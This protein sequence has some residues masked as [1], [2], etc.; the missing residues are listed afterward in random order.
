MIWRSIWA[1][2][3]R[4]SD[5]V[6]DQGGCGYRLF[7]GGERCAA[8]RQ[9]ITI[10]A[11]CNGE[12]GVRENRAR[13]PGAVRRNEAAAERGEDPEGSIRPRVALRRLRALVTAY[14]HHMTDEVHG[15][16]SGRIWRWLQQELSPARGLGQCSPDTPCR[17][18]E[19]AAGGTR[20]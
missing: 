19:T 3:W 2:R 4:V 6:A 13:L 8:T 1:Q 18:S 17:L 15:W 12:V 5:R 14:R 7:A 9:P 16:L 10:E 20:P 11:Q